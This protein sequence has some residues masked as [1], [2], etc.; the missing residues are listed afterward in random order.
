MKTEATGVD[1]VYYFKLVEGVCDFSHASTVAKNA[2]VKQE[3][4]ERSEM[5]LQS[6]VSHQPFVLDEGLINK[7]EINDLMSNFLDLNLDN[8]D[9]V[10]EF[11]EKISVL[12]V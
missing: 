11:M 10:A 2:G 6:I 5:I 9:E 4:V 12:T 8:D 3:V 7:K 1:L